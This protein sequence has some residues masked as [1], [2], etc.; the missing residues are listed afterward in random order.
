MPTSIFTPECESRLLEIWRELLE[1]TDKDM[2]TRSSEEA[3]ATAKLN[4]YRKEI[5]LD[6]EFTAVQVSNKMDS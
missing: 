3:K 5:G 2:A 1:A 4:A 6:R